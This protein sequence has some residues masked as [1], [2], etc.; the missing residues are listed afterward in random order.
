MKSF[1]YLLLTVIA[2]TLL[3]SCDDTKDDDSKVVD[4]VQLSVSFKTPDLDNLWGL[5]WEND[6]HYDWDSSDTLYGPLG[7]S[8]PEMIK[9]TVYNIDSKTGKRVN[10]FL[11]LFDF[12]GSSVSLPAGCAYDML[13]YNLGTEKVKF[14]ASDDYQNYTASSDKPDSAYIY[15]NTSDELSGAMVTGVDFSKASSDSDKIDV[16][17]EPYSIIYLFQVVIV[18]NTDSTGNRRIME[19]KKLTVSGLAQGVNLFTRQTIPAGIVISTQDIK[20]IQNHS[21]LR[22]SDGTTLENAD[23][24]AAR[25]LTWGLPGVAPTGGIDKHDIFIT[26][27]LSDGRLFG[28]A[29]NITDQMEN[30]PAGGVITVYVDAEQELIYDF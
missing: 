14:D 18:N 28:I 24:L 8:V 1:R 11:K 4:S 13:F 10:S 6:W 9:A 7:Y 21:G 22:L 20:P 27:T 2:V 17:L 16:D 15:F 30:K 25:I 19:A 26:F 3:A 23:I 29:K 5:D 12:K